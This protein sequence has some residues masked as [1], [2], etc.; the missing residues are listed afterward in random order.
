[1]MQ[2]NRRVELALF[3][4]PVSTVL[5]GHPESLYAVKTAI[6]PIQAKVCVL[7]ERIVLIV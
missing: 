2:E 3:N 6:S 5:A 4:G 7:C 1:M